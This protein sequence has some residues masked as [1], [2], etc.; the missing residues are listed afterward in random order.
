LGEGLF[1][2]LDYLLEHFDEGTYG[3]G[4]V[5]FAQKYLEAIGNTLN[6]EADNMY[7][8]ENGVLSFNFTESNGNRKSINVDEMVQ[9]IAQYEALRELDT[10]TGETINILD[11]F[12]TNFDTIFNN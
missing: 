8:R 7:S 10:V 4:I 11:N 9:I 1:D 2:N 3:R 12:N 6:I 5:T